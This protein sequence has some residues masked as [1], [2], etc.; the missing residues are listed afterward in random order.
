VPTDGQWVVMATSI[1]EIATASFAA[2]PNPFTEQL[3]I[4]LKQAQTT[5]IS[6]Y[7][8]SGK[9]IFSKKINQQNIQLDLSNYNLN[10][11]NY[12]LVI[13]SNNKTETLK[14]IKQ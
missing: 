2:Y 13:E 6:L 7:D 3:H 11:G 9:L 1:N 12:N 5:A 14:L 8:N 10:A 4:E